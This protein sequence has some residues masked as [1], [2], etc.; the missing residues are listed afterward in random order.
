MEDAVRLLEYLLASGIEL[1]DEP[2]LHAR[3][4]Q[5][6]SKLSQGA[7]YDAHYLAL[8][9]ILGC[10]YWTA[11]E[12]FLPLGCFLCPKRALDRRV[13]RAGIVSKCNAKNIR[14]S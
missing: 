6:A 8:A 11:D 10:E 12:R 3:A 9:D 2:D 4:L 5:V 13:R 14:Q 7:V 1:R